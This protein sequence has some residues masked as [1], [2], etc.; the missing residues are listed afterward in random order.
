[1]KDLL[2]QIGLQL[3][4]NL[5]NAIKKYEVFGSG[6]LLFAIIATMPKL[7]P[8]TLQDWWTWVQSALQT[9][10]PVQQHQQPQIEV[11]LKAVPAEE[12]PKK[13]ISVVPKL[14]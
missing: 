7:I 12:A 2:Y 14:D 3:L 4:Q 5:L 8:K 1:M 6:V 13:D 10:L 11:P 9:V